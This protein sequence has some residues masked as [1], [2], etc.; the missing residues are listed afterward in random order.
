MASSSSCGAGAAKQPGPSKQPGP[1]MVTG[2]GWAS[3]GG[4]GTYRARERM[5]HSRSLSRNLLN[6][7]GFWM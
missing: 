1:Q 7:P 6:P 2:R 5:S 3:G 4:E